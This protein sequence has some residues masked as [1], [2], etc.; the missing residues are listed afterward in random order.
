MTGIEKLIKN[1]WNGVRDDEFGQNGGD[2]IADTTATAGNWKVVK[3]ITACSFTAL[4]CSE[5]DNF[6]GVA[7]A[8][9]DVIYGPFTNITLAS[10]SVIAYHRNK[11]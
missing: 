9:G 5:G 10:G 6:D 2:Y 8:A 1:I 4:T 11:V 3:C 7:L